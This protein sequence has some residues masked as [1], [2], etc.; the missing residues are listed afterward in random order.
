MGLPA[1]SR[2]D[3]LLFGIL[4]ITSALVALGSWLL[5]PPEKTGGMERQPSTLFNVAYGAK[6]GYQVLDRL[7]YPVA[8]L[9][10]RIE[11]ETLKGIGVLF[12]LKPWIGLDDHEVETL[13]EWIKDGHALV[14]VPG[15]SSDF[16]LPGSSLKEWFRFA[17]PPDESKSQ[18]GQASLRHSLRHGLPTV[19]QAQPADGTVRRPCHNRGDRWGRHSCLPDGPQFRGQTRM[20]APP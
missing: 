7:G 3:R 17:E 12:V 20:S 11:P 6:A 14:V 2:T 10:R 5:A 13:E 15:R 4:L 8:R 9:R 19:P 16:H 18:A 1:L